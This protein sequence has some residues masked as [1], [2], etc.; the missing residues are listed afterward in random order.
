[1]YFHFFPCSSPKKG[2]KATG[3]LSLSVV[4]AQRLSSGGLTSSFF[5][6]IGIM[7][8]DARFVNEKFMSA[9][10]FNP[11]PNPQNRVMHNIDIFWV[12]VHL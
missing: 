2:D 1:M 4:F 8:Y 11:I 12:W 5:F 10:R 9:V 3:M 6:H 7:N